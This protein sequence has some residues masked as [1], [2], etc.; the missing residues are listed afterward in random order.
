[1]K[2]HKMDEKLKRIAESMEDL[3][4]E[5]TTKIDPSYLN[6]RERMLFEK[7]CKI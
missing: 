7:V 6:E 3:P 2:P 5:G 4:I 1:M